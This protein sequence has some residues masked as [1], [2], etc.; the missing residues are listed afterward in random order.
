MPC[1]RGFGQEVGK[2]EFR[3][4]CTC[5]RLGGGLLEFL[6]DAAKAAARAK[7]QTVGVIVVSAVSGSVC[8][9]SVDANANP[10]SRFDVDKAVVA[11][12]GAV[13]IK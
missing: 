4:C 10:D 11:A 12:V 8:I 3:S 5:R 9:R 1:R 7:G 13:Q 2:S 6:D